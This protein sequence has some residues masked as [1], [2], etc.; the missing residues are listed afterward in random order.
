MSVQSRQ[1]GKILVGSHDAKPIVSIVG[2]A[3][4]LDWIGSERIVYSSMAGDNLNI[5]SIGAD[6]FNKAQLTLDGCDY[7]P[8]TTSDGQL[9]VFASYRTGGLNIWRMNAADGGDLRQ[10]TFTDGNSYPS[11]SRDGKW[12]VYDNQSSSAFTVWKVPIDGGDPVQLT[13]KYT[14]MP[15]MSPDSQFMACRYLVEG[16]ARA[17]GIFS[18]A[19][20]APSEPLPIRVM[21]WQRI[22]W[23]PDGRALTYVAT[24]N[25]VSNIWSY[26]LA[27]KST[28]RLTDFK[29]TEQIFAYAWSPDFKQLASL[30][31]TESRDVTLISNQK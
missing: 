18:F 2:R 29:T 25:G 7:T 20:G 19:G 16:G 4:G 28:K 5:S 31:G 27:T 3:Y 26:D 13:D 8:A 1:D 11:L 6:G 14:R 12:V 23:N 9:I 17:I 22:Q 30:R 24:D 15:A 21:E 10:L